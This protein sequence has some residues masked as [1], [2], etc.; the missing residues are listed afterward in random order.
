MVLSAAIGVVFLVFIVGV[1][2]KVACPQMSDVSDDEP[3]EY[4]V[5]EEADDGFPPLKSKKKLTVV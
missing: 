3:E 2:Y 1:V 5:D 4:E